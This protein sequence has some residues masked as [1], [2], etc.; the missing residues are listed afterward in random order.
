MRVYPRQHVN[1][2]V[3]FVEQI[4]QLANLGLERPHALLKRLC[5]TTWEG[6]TAEL[7]ACL[8]LEADVDALSAAG[9]DAVAAN[10]LGA[11][12]VAGLGNARLGGGP[13]LDNFHGKNSRHG[14]G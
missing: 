12:S 1:L 9:A 7:V 13:D 2:L 4:L 8:A 11:T 5:V 14:G 10:F 6:A 3:F